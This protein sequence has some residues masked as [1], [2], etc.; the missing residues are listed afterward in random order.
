V[1]ILA[2]VVSMPRR[3][4]ARRL[5]LSNRGPWMTDRKVLMVHPAGGLV[6]PPAFS[7]HQVS[8]GP[9]VDLT[10][11]DGSERPL[12]LP[13]NQFDLQREVLDVVPEA[14]ACDTLIVWVVEDQCLPRGISRFRGRK[15]LIIGDTHHMARPLQA[16]MR[17]AEEESFDAVFVGNRHH[18]HWLRNVG[19]P[20]LHWLPAIA[21][22]PAYRAFSPGNRSGIVL[23]GQIGNRH[24]RR[25]WLVGQL[26][27]RG[28]PIK[29]FACEPHEMPLHYGN[30]LISLNVSLNGDPNFRFYEV[31]AAGG[32]L[33]TDRTSELAGVQTYYQVGEHYDDFGNLDE[34]CAKLDHYLAH[35][36]AALAIAERSQAHYMATLDRALIVERFWRAVDTGRDDPAFA[37]TAEKRFARRK[38]T[39][40]A[41]LR[42]DVALYEAVQE[43]HRISEAPNV[44]LLPG[45]SRRLATDCADLPRLNLWVLD[46]DARSAAEAS[47]LRLD[48]HVRRMSLDVARQNTFDLVIGHDEGAHAALGIRAL[49]WI[50]AGPAA[51]T[52]WL[53]IEDSLGK[54]AMIAPETVLLRVPGTGE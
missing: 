47:D 23:L 28:Y 6:L 43:L 32:F 9:A 52:V 45:L 7:T 35:P 33:L 12:R 38:P 51:A 2:A 49:R 39:R 46:D 50:V 18:A 30:A 1:I 19:V 15:V 5:N 40:Y 41:D 31:P 14:K 21:A 29:A 16:A 26:K 36:E 13:I 20:N 42:R 44:L 10:L 22:Q 34:L 24:P 27:E 37:L 48:H 54:V 4:S 25:M 11:P 53:P 8:A 3:R 17:Y